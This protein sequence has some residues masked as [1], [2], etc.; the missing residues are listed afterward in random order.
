[1][2][3][4]RKGRSL[5]F[6]V[7]CEIIT[8]WSHA[9][10]KQLWLWLC[11]LWIDS[12]QADILTDRQTDRQ[13]AWYAWIAGAQQT[14]LPL[15]QEPPNGTER[16]CSAHVC[17]RGRERERKRRE[18][19][20]EWGRDTDIDGMWIRLLGGWM[21]EATPKHRFRNQFNS[22]G[23]ARQQTAKMKKL[24]LLPLALRLAVTMSRKSATKQRGINRNRTPF[25]S[26]WQAKQSVRLYEQRAL[27]V[28]EQGYKKR[29]KATLTE[30]V[31]SLY[32]IR[33]RTCYIECDLPG[34][35]IK[36]TTAC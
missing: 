28:G 15:T 3:T 30:I 12:S 35:L 10:A 6:A 21:S 23:V 20:W 25:S 7:I 18:R 5:D 22:Y 33:V 31:I 19:G 26:V 1:M 27:A 32:Y 14:R 8:Y 34:W 4:C 13:A 24:R 29:I 11:Q 36:K 9:Q 17:Q 2:E 16:L